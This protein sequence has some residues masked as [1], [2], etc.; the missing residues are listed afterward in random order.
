MFPAL[1]LLALSCGHRVWPAN[2]HGHHRDAPQDD[3]TEVHGL[4]QLHDG[5]PLSRAPLQLALAITATQT[6]PR[7][8]PLAMAVD[9]SSVQ[10]TTTLSSS[11]TSSLTSIPCATAAANH[12]YIMPSEFSLIS[13]TQEIFVHFV[14][15]TPIDEHS[16]KITPCHHY[17][18]LYMRNSPFT[19]R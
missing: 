6:T 5:A 7:N 12:W 8:L 10:P 3:D 16:T 9:L 19:S 11:L 14:V 1:S 17:A 2:R 4:E 13:R 15:Q 18:F